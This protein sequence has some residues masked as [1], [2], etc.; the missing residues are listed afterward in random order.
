VFS[1]HDD[2]STDHG[3]QESALAFGAGENGKEMNGHAI[4]SRSAS[5]TEGTSTGYNRQWFLHL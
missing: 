5:K 2:A 3:D 1:D 4:G